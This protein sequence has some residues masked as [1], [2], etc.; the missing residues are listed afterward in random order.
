MKVE[1]SAIKLVKTTENATKTLPKLFKYLDLI[2]SVAD[3]QDYT[4]KN[5]KLPLINWS[6]EYLI[7]KP[8]LLF[9]ILLSAAL[10]LEQITPQRLLSMTYVAEGLSLSWYLL[11]ELKRDL[12]RK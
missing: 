3:Y 6:V 7:I 10:F 8:F 2:K 5:I 4:K 12:W 9:I 11:T 1:E